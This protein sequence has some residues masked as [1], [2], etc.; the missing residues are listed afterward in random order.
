MPLP[1]VVPLVESLIRL[2]NFCIDENDRGIASLQ[3]KNL[4]NLTDTVRYSRVNERSTDAELVR[5]GADGRP[6]SLLGHGHHFA[7]A[8]HNRRS[9]ENGT[10]MDAMI[11]S[12]RLQQLKRPPY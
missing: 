5:I 8:P 1:K 7:D 10:P 9:D 3:G 12:V 11:E 6:S 2:H 4:N